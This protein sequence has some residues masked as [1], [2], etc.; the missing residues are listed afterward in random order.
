MKTSAYLDLQLPNVWYDCVDDV[1]IYRQVV[2]NAAAWGKFDIDRS[3]RFLAART[4]ALA[5]EF[6]YG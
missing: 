5:L 4:D 6:T 1:V 3:W 2:S